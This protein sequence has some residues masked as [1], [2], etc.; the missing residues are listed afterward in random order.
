MPKRILKKGELIVS[1]QVME[2]KGFVQRARGLIGRRSLSAEEVF[3]IPR[4]LSIHT[5]FMRFSIDVIFVDQNFRILSLFEN[6]SSGKILFGGFK[7]LHVFE[8]RG[9]RISALQ[10]QKG[11]LLNVEP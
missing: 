7:S 5:F 8:M 2:A 11:D 3:W 6:V 10:L 9:G 1:K 4:C